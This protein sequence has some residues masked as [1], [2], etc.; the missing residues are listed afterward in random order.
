MP[1]RPTIDYRVEQGT[2][3]NQLL[4]WNDTTKLF[5]VSVSLSG[6]TLN[7]P[8]IEGN[9]S[10]TGNDTTLNMTSSGKKIAFN[11]GSGL[12][13]SFVA[14]SRNWIN[15]WAQFNKIEFGNTTDN[16]TYDF[17]GTGLTTLGGDI[18]VEGGFIGDADDDQLIELDG[19]GGIV[20]VDAS[21]GVGKSPLA[22]T[23]LDVLGTVGTPG[24]V[25]FGLELTGGDGGTGV[26]DGPPV[27]HE[28]GRGGQCLLNT[29]IGGEC[30]TGT[31][32]NDAG[33]GGQLSFITG[34]GGLAN[35][36]VAGNNTGG[37]GGALSLFLGNGGAANGAT[38]GDNTGGGGASMGLMA[39]NGGAASNSSNAN[40]GGDGGDVD[41]DAGAGGVGT[42]AGPSTGANGQIYFGRTVN[43]PTA[44]P[45]DAGAIWNDSGTLKI[46]AGI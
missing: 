18:V 24:N 17:L 28:S 42:G 45:V 12:G 31:G 26:Q 13:L 1:L 8:V 7:S 41:I 5:E 9:F 23:I 4:V 25:G 40:I 35:N 6:L 32:I 27:R 22:A 34:E 36:A 46:S 38:S 37:D 29:G 33:N 21:L 39:G 16:Q 2:A 3:D 30:N 15:L 10:W 44:D 19:A 11:S 43:L 20:T 14:S